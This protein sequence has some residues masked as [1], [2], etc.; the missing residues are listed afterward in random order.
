MSKKLP[1]SQSTG[2]PKLTTFFKRLENQD[3][4]T[5]STPIEQNITKS[6]NV[7][8]DISIDSDDDSDSF[9][10]SNIKK[11]LKVIDNINL[12]SSNDLSN[13]NTFKAQSQESNSSI[14]QYVE[15]SVEEKE[16][17][18][19]I[20]KSTTSDIKDSCKK[21]I[22]F[23]QLSESEDE[24]K[25]LKICLRLNNGLKQTEDKKES[26]EIQENPISNTDTSLLPVYNKTATMSPEI[27]KHN[28]F[29]SYNI[30]EEMKHNTNE[31]LIM[32]NVVNQD[33]KDYKKR[34]IKKAT[35][36]IISDSD[37]DNSDSKETVQMTP[38][39][40]WIGP[41]YKL[42][43]K[44]LGI[45]KQL[46][47]WIQSIKEK[48]IMS[49]LPGT[50]NELED[51][52]Q[53]LQDLQ[54][55][56]LEKFFVAISEIPLPILEKFPK[57]NADAFH[58]LKIFNQHVKAKL[59]LVNKKLENMQKVE[60]ELKSTIDNQL[61]NE[62]ECHSPVFK[63]HKIVKSSPI[64]LHNSKDSSMN[65]S[66]N[67]SSKEIVSPNETL[68]GLSLSI[69]RSSLSPCQTDDTE[70]VNVKTSVNTNS[71]VV[72]TNTNTATM[73]KSTF[74]L[75]RPVRATICTEVTKKIGE[76]WE[77]EQ[78]QSRLLKIKS[79][80]ECD[81]VSFKTE[82]NELVY[83]NK[84]VDYDYSKGKEF[85]QDAQPTFNQMDDWINNSKDFEDDVMEN[86]NKSITETFKKE[87]KPSISLNDS[88]NLDLSLSMKATSSPEKKK[89]TTTNNKINI[90]LNTSVSEGIFT[91][92]YKNDGISGEFDGLN[93]PHSREMLKIF[94]QKFGL[95]SFR[96]NQL[97]AIN[98]ALL[99][100]DCFVLMPTG[101]GKSLCYQMPALL[102]PGVT[103]VISPLKSLILDQVQKLT[104]LDIP[105]AHMSG[106]ITENQSAGIYR[107]LSKKEPGLK[108]LYVTPEKI[109][110]SQK[111]S[112]ILTTLFQR[113]L[114][115]RFV[116]DEA[117]CVSQWGHDFR[118]D[119]KKLKCLRE[120]YP[121][122]STIA[123]T[124]TATPRVR[125]DIL[126]QLGMT[127]PKWFMS[128]FNRPNLR[129]SIIAKK[130]KNCSDEVIAMIKTKFKNQC[131][132][133]YCLSRKDCDDY[134]L[135]MR[136]NNIQAQSY[137]A[138]LTDNQR[139]DIQGRWI[140]EEM[141]I[142]CATIAFGMGID[143]PNVR[144]VIHAALPK[145][146]EGYYQESG[147][148]GRDG[149]NAECILFYNYADM[150]RIRKM[151]EIDN[152]N[153]D[154]IKTHM[155]NL[156]KMVSFCENKT[157]CRRALQLNY[158]G[159]IFNRE[160][161]IENK[162][163][164]C[165]NCRCKAEFTMLDAT[166]HARQIMKAVRE[167][168]QRKNS[169]LTL[170]FLT[171]IF[172]GSDLKKIRESG[173][174]NH[175][176]YGQ[177]KSW[178]RGDIERL[179]HEMVL[180]EYLR[181]EM[182]INNEIACAYLKIGHKATE[183][184]TKK[185]TK[186]IIPIRAANSSSNAVAT[187]STVTT[188]VN[189]VLQELQ[190][191]CYSELIGI[192]RG[193]AGALD[194]SASSI[195]NMIA[196]R[197]MSQQLP[198]SEEAMLKIPHVTKANF[199]KYGKAL[200]DI[201]QKYAAEKYVLLSEADEN[202][203]DSTDEDTS[204]WNTATNSSYSGSTRGRYGSTQ[205][206]KRKGYNNYRSSTKKARYTNSS[207]QKGKAASKRKTAAAKPT[208]GLVSFSKKK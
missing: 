202:S 7:K 198:D 129:Y 199:D 96:P 3:N 124:A 146:I 173:L 41:D 166:N 40:K 33:I 54:I 109:S 75:K 8:Y 102:V 48:P 115:A 208:L 207:T 16:R 28:S 106:N 185:D 105:A 141:R 161:C 45:D 178:N 121:T 163:S 119:Y 179:L 158:F 196:I 128:S 205:G 176:L 32:E 117:H 9:I 46:I 17:L 123:L 6:S 35:N 148:A 172:K 23:E 174:T 94:R 107:E 76:L 73:R 201:T 47:S 187:V 29:D 80:S 108:L 10:S 131:G 63:Q 70:K 60:K 151:I 98:A 2:V 192:I 184:M 169:K 153:P 114:L 134:A 191:R 104:S 103:I 139:S 87:Y 101:G 1:I 132:I 171:D 11:E 30:P 155:D 69:T 66:L 188:K 182:Y 140:S 4:L 144:F 165:D 78:Q 86:K 167:I 88:S 49:S 116:I 150:H 52:R 145:S 50:E 61:L 81:N 72:S 168:N 55:E 204:S 37:N 159:E 82:Q 5:S 38:R 99:G 135:Q 157:D 56:I 156:F 130:G 36:I 127:K 84:K 42:N 120:N 77:K 18:E 53:G 59:R 162:S 206:R 19:N 200:L 137:H 195:M 34:N 90:N 164:A 20:Q 133:V 111:L 203:A 142:V 64:N 39:K 190:E 14:V 24:C 136:K 160:K 170:V 27:N 89:S 92:N 58:K 25:K 62:P 154:V 51:R 193:I 71:P 112:S 138:G 149:E 186:V 113:N 22:F 79:D 181:E 57:F 122:V 175:P 194:V 100:F 147:R 93:Y 189:K 180:K 12:E 126:Y 74:Q 67:S 43:L 21:K 85:Q 91:G 95:Y 68:D 26:P 183:L 197:A 110:A 65:L 125:T 15:D 177:G 44:P 13:Q 83:Q 152:S 143:K 118:P 97:Q 31:N